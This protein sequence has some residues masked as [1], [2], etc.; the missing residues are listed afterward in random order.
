MNRAMTYGDTTGGLKVVVAIATA[1]LLVVGLVYFLGIQNTFAVAPS[2]YGLKEGDVVSAAGS[3]DPDVYIVN[4]LGYKRLF[5]NPAIFGFYG[6]L[7]GFAAVKNV[8]PATRDAF[9]TSGLFRNCE[10]NDQKVYGVQT[11]GEDTGMLHWVNTSGAQAV[12]DDA[13]FFK[14]VFCINNNEF[15]WYAKGSDYSSVNQVPS[16]VRVPGATP[17]PT[18]PLSVSL[19]PDNPAAAT[20]TKNASGV[21]FLK[22]RFTGSGTL[23]SMVLKRL[24]AGET[25]DFS[26]VYIYDGAKRLTSGKTFSSATG[27]AT[28]LVNV[29]VSGTKDLT[30]V[31]DMDSTNGTAGNVNYISL[32]SVGA[33]GTVSGT[34]VNGNNMSSSGASSGRLDVAKVGSLANPTVG[35]KQAQLSE[36]KLTANTE[37]ASVRRVTMINGG[38]LKP[39]D[40]TNVK[41]KAGTSEWSGSVTSDS[42]LVFDLGSG[43][44]IAKGGNAVF[45]VYG[46]TGGKAAETVDLYFENAADLYAVGDQYGQGMSTDGSTANQGIADLDTAT[47]ATTLTL[48]GGV[49]TLVFNGPIAA[50][51]GTQ[52]T[53]VTLLRYSMTAATNIEIRKTELT[54]CGSNNGATDTTF[55][56]LA[57]EA[58]ND[59]ITDIKIWNEDTNQVVIGP[60]DGIDMNTSDTASCPDSVEGSQ[61]ILTDVLDLVAGKTY[62]FKVTA[63]IDTSTNTNAVGFPAADD[64]VRIVLDSY[65]DD[66]TTSGDV[67]IMKYSG[68]N[69]GVK[70]TDISP[71]A[72]IS[73]PNITVISASLTMG[74]AG[75]PGDQ[76]YVKGTKDVNVVGLTFAAAQASSIKV[77]DITLTGYADEDSV[78]GEAYNE[79]VDDDAT[80]GTDTGTAVGNAITNVRLY[81][82]ESGALIGDSSKVSSNALATDDNGTI[83]FSSLAWT[84]P[85]GTTKTLLVKADLT[86]N[87]AS[88]SEGDFYAFDIA[89]TS[90]VTALDDSS[91]TVNPTSVAKNGTTSPTTTLTVLNGGYLTISNGD[92][93]N[94]GPHFW[95]ETDAAFNAIKLR[96]TNEAF[97]VERFNVFNNLADDTKVDVIANVDHVKLGY[98]TKAQAGSANWTWVTQSLNNDTAPSTSFAFLGD[99]R[100][101]VPKDTSVDVKI[102]ADIKPDADRY[103]DALTNVDGTEVSF[104]LDFS[105]G[106]A[107]EFKAVGEGSGSIRDGDP[108]NDVPTSGTVANLTGNDQYVYRV[109]PKIEQITVPAGEPIGTK[110]VLKFKITAMGLPGARV[111]FDDPSSVAL[112]WE[113]I[114]SRSNS[115]NPDNTFN[116]YDVDLGT[117]YASTSNDPGDSATNASV[118]FTEWEQDVSVYVGSPKTFRIEGVF[119][120]FTAQSDYFQLVMRDEAG[121]IQ[122]VDGADA[123]NNFVSNAASVFQILPMTGPTFSK[124]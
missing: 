34:P 71:N 90:D 69:T 76:T 80:G 39:V 96:A 112:K 78:G 1:M 42:Y 70:S 19:A 100:P 98:Q 86:T 15:N 27:E 81:E 115:G 3:D 59:N 32:I 114:A 61:E 79:G 47:E 8:S 97:F 33:S 92:Q 123:D 38:T 101:Y 124:L 102:R 83:K 74:L 93:P 65:G 41:L 40:L 103:G 17:A 6:H 25:N 108:T 9:G 121:V 23:S 43:H 95:G 64:I 67:T 72:D 10:T 12:A 110:D 54:L 50:N 21:N 55:E 117:L 14:K 35:Q 75:T 119:A 84:I 111:F 26:N 106:A 89:T 45:K 28:F 16:Y 77:T 60:V 66:A 56:S 53:D 29:A 24:G 118:S 36:F 107:D 113:V 57:T 116:L 30:V 109:F 48:Q 18:G 44:T 58:D 37:G 82:G 22:V 11:T 99:A 62:N 73:G 88:G 49:L 104:S 20:I 91:N 7:G 120:G 46:D 13:N 2:D 105:G 85:A 122:Y 5:L 94:T 52:S 4:E 68:T 51:V 87:D 63:D 31:A